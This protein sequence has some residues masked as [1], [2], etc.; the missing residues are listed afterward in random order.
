[1]SDDNWHCLTM[2]VI[3]G[4]A[5]GKNMHFNEKN[6]HFACVATKSLMIHSIERI[7]W[8]YCVFLPPF[9][10]KFPILKSV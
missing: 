4:I 1:M 2:K 7:I 8:F 5:N 10:R 3:L 9:F 6:M